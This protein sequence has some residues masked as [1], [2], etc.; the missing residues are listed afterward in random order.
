MPVFNCAAWLPHALDSISAQSF[1]DFEL[2]V[3]DDGSTDQSCRVVEDAAH[4]D[5]RIRLVR[6]ARLGI[7]TALNRAVAL[8]RSPIIARMDGDD[9]AAPDRLQTQMDFLGA[10]PDVA[11]VG[12]WA[13]V[14]GHRSE[15]IGELRPE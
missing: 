4:S 6:Q 3:V 8:A 9:V 12:S 14:I 11:A 10:H 1:P 7:S 2:I 15:V 5:S 13:R